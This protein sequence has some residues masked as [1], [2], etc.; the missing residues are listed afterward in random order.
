[1]GP[2]NNAQDPLV[3]IVYRLFCWV[4]S[5]LIEKSKITAQKKKKKVDIKRSAFQLTK[6]ILLIS[7][8]FGRNFSCQCAIRKSTTTHFTSGQIPACFGCF[9]HSGQF[10]PISGGMGILANTGFAF[11]KKKYI[12]IYIY[13]LQLRCFTSQ[14]RCSQIHSH[15]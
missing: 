13:I 6:P 2:I 11:K 4:N 5:A 14:I 3:C 1:M 8:C 12:Y 7:F 15:M 10:R 9:G